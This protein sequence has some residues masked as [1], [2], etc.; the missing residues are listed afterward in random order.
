MTDIVRTDGVLGGEPRLD[1][2]RISVLQV[3]DMVL[4]AGHQ[5]EYVADQ[6]DISLAE[7]HSALAYYYEYPGEMDE[8][9]ERHDRLESEL[10][11]RTATP[12]HVEQ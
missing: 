8:I 4:E 3:A 5:P 6:L 2:H 10:A 12:D 1:G 7:V 11:E 9:R